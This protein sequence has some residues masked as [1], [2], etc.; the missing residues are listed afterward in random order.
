MTNGDRVGAGA[1][2]LDMDHD[3]DLD[4][5]V[6]NYLVFS[7]DK[8]VDRFWR[9]VPMYPGPKDHPPETNTLYRNNGDGTFTDVSVASGIAAYPGWGMGTVCLDY[10]NDGDTDIYVANDVAANSLFQNDGTG[11]FVDVGLE[12][13]S[14]LDVAGREQGSMGPECGDYNN[15]GWL[16]LYVT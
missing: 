5:F 14:A 15:D 3:G 9:G 4:L 16:D 13:G 11:R 7:Y 8:H 1:N 12:S 6:S 10:D 2:F